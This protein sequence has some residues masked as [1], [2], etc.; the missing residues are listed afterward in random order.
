[1]NWYG[2]GRHQLSQDTTGRRRSGRLTSGGYETP[3]FDWYSNQGR[4]PEEVEDWWGDVAPAVKPRRP[5][6][7]E[8]DDPTWIAVEFHEEEFAELLAASAPKS[9][10][11]GEGWVYYAQRG[12]RIKIG[13]SLRPVDRAQLFGTL[14]AVEPGG[15]PKEL[16]RHWQFEAFRLRG[17]W[18]RDVPEIRSLIAECPRIL[19]ELRYIE[20]LAS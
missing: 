20:G 1:M 9:Q 13:T 16:L 6:L 11:S 8:W 15:Y 17:E 2:T 7:T 14:L 4:F 19:N 3:L 18:F 10:G 12:E 5:V